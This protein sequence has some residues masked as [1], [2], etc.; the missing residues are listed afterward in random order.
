M[1]NKNSLIR[2]IAVIGVITMMALVV[3][4]G[5]S[6]IGKA[7]VPEEQST[8]DPF[9]LDDTVNVGD[10]GL[11]QCCPI[12]QSVNFKGPDEMGYFVCNDCGAQWAENE[13]AI[14]VTMPDGS[15][16]QLDPSAGLRP[17]GGS[18]GGSGSGSSGGSNNGSGNGSSGGSNNGSGNGSGNSGGSYTPTPTTGTTKSLQQQIDEIKDRWGDVIK[19]TIDADGNITV[20]SVDGSDTGLFGFKYSTKDK[21]FIT[22]ENAWQRN[23]GYNETYDASAPVIAIT[24]DTI[25]VYFDYDGLEWMIQYWKGQYGLVLVGAEIGVYNRAAGSSASTHFNCADD[26][27]KLLQSMDVYRR[28]PD[29]AKYNKIFS[30]SPSFTWWCTGFIPGTLAAGQYNV[31]AEATRELKVD[32]KI[33]LK[34]PEMAQAFIEGLRQVDHI[35]HNA[36]MTKPTF[37]FTEMASV[38]EY[39]SSSKNGK[40][41]LEEDGVTVRVCWR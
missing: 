8:N 25:R 29:S 11:E 1:F 16:T 24:Y 6:F 28:A 7:D 30:R 21:C 23:F 3:L 13:Q 26:E 18:S 22:A 34:T 4:P 27:T 35:Y 12:C 14:D 10:T 5:C 19:P 40:F 41:V 2:A 15:V 39:E 33:T 20:E 36:P 38:A 37:K 9:A 31:E 17:N 32:S